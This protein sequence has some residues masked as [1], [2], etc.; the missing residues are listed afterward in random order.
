MKLTTLHKI[1]GNQ[2]TGETQGI[3][4]RHKSGIRFFTG[5]ESETDPAHELKYPLFYLAPISVVKKVQEAN[6]INTWNIVCEL[7][8]IL[9][10]DRDTERVN[11]LLD[12]L[13]RIMEDLLL[14]FSINYSYGK[15]ITFNNFTETLYFNIGDISIIPV[16]DTKEANLTGW[17]ASFAITEQINPNDVVCCLDE[18]F[19]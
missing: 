18:N 6:Y 16:I 12:R 3:V 19:T 2:T 5:K 17:Q 8:D 1:F 9:P 15:S 13:Y 7:I 11:E 4:I 14:E 10:Q